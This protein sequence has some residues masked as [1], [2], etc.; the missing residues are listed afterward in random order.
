MTK[1]DDSM[2]ISYPPCQAACPIL[3]DAREYIQR[4]AERR[5]EEAFN[6]VRKLNPLPGVCGRICTHPCEA[7]CKRGQVEE[8]I[9]IAALKRFASDGPWTGQYRAVL[10]DKPTGHKVAVVGSGPAGLSA[11]QDLA[12][13]GHQVTIFEGLPVLGGMLRVGMPGYRLP[14][15]VVD[16]E[17]RSIADLGVEIKTGVRI[18]EDFTISDLFDQGYQAVFLA[19]GAHKDRKL[20]VPGEEGLEGVVSAVSFLREVNQGENPE[21]GKSVAVIGGGNTAVDSCRSACRLGARE[22][23]MIYRRGSEEMPA[24]EEEIREAIQEG[25]QISYLTSPVEILGKDGKVSALKCIKNELGK[26][27]VSGRRSPKPI[28]G[29]EFTLDVDMVIAA[30]GQA[31]D[32]SLIAD[33]VGVTER[34]KRIIVDGPYTLV[35]TQPGV[36]A[37][38]DAVTGPATA[39][40]AISAGKRAAISIDLYVRGKP[41]PTTEAP[42]AHETASLPQRLIDRTKTF[43]RSRKASISVDQRLKGFDEVDLVFSEEAATK[44]ALRCL[45]CY[46]GAKVDTEKCVSCLTCVR[47]CPLGIPTTSKMGEITIDAYLC[48]ACGVCVLEC[49]VRAIDINLGSRGEIAQHIEEAISSS[50]QPGPAIVGFFDLHGNFASKDVESL[51]QDYPNILPLMVFGLRRLD[52]SDILK[53]FEYGADGVFLAACQPDRD[54]FPKE[55]ER[56]KQRAAHARTLLEALG[57]DGGRLEI[58]DMP[59]EGLV[60]K[61]SVAEMIQRLGNSGQ[62]RSA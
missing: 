39:V 57:I 29:S 20:G 42:K 15:D 1:N 13:F 55:T 3:T 60:E 62:A 19:I 17:I 8:P 56:V 36:F 47:V 50:K 18:G 61:E 33:D 14:K 58:F 46:L 37:G 35:T 41:V 38:G 44:E 5:Y 59:Q 52:T 51:A 32:S 27:D 34:R 7:A 48:Q 28:P 23:H 11:A 53:A 43:A 2:E 25:V 49:P 16:E 22:V 4:I 54:P 45:H 31:P 30:I 10:P 6:S 24:A 12:L 26:P 21:V 40:E 9:A